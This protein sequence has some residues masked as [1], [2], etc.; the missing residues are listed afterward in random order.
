VVRDVGFRRRSCF[1]ATN[2]KHEAHTTM[3][4]RKATSRAASP[5]PAQSDGDSSMQDS[6]MQSPQ[7][8]ETFAS[9]LHSDNSVAGSAGKRDSSRNPA[10]GGA[11]GKGRGRGV[12]TRNRFKATNSESP[13]S[14]NDFAEMS[15]GAGNKGGRRAAVKRSILQPIREAHT[16]HAVNPDK[17]HVRASGGIRG[18]SAQ[19]ARTSPATES[20][21]GICDENTQDDAGQAAAPF[22]QFQV[23]HVLCEDVLAVCV[24]LVL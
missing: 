6:H 1:Q 23:T 13:L 20:V 9:P 12:N 3:P 22:L 14:D 7:P 18:K 11:E 8:S 16:P 4:R 10:A 2:F 19:D 5:A 17:T 24:H 15:K 21:E